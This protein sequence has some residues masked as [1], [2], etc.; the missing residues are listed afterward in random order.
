DAKLGER[1]MKAVACEDLKGVLK[2]LLIE[3][4][5][6][7]PKGANTNGA[8]V[9][10]EPAAPAAAPMNPPKATPYKPAP[11]VSP[12]AEPAQPAT[13]VFAKTGQEVACDDSQSILEIAAAAGVE[14]ESSCESGSCSTCQQKRI[15][16]EIRYEGEPDGLDA[17]EQEAGMILTCIAHPV[18][19]VVLEA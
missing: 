19:R 6:A 12:P 18:G 8:A 17:A 4:F 7:T 16:G 15:S 10:T 14:F 11:M 5:G 13:L 2:A 9:V 1:V 3:Q